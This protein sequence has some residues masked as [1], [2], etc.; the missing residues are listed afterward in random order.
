VRTDVYSVIADVR[1]YMEEDLILHVPSDKRSDVRASIKLLS[2]ICDEVDVL[3][4]LL[5]KECVEAKE[6]CNEVKEALN[7]MDSRGKTIDER[8]VRI[9]RKIDSFDHSLMPN[10]L[11]ALIKKKDEAN[12]VISNLCV[13]LQSLLRSGELQFKERNKIV[14]I[15]SSIY[16]ML[17]SWSERRAEWQSVFDGKKKI[18]EWCSV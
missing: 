17:E 14:R 7:R 4:C 5:D 9:F 3:H 1:A 6:I 13:G 10:T 18:L 11:S 15:L 2:E 16:E 12:I 8:S